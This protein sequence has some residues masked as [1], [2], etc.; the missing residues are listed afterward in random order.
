MIRPGCMYYKYKGDEL[1]KYRIVSINKEDSTV[2]VKDNDGKRSTIPSSDLKNYVELLPDAMLHLMI[3]EKG[4]YKDV[5]VCIHRYDAIAAGK[6]EPAVIV[7]QDAINDLGNFTKPGDKIVVG[8]CVTQQTLIGNAGIMDHVDFD[9]VLFD[10]ITYI[11]LDDTLDSI[12]S[13]IS[14]S[15]QDKTNA[16]LRELTQRNNDMI[17]GYCS[18]LKE[19]LTHVNFMYHYRSIFNINQVDWMVTTIPGKKPDTFTLPTEQIGRIQDMLRKYITNVMAIAYD[20]DLDVSK[21]VSYKHILIS[22]KSGKIYLVA[23][24]EVGNYAVDNDIAKAMGVYF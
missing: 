7:R 18:S 13:V 6:N 22:D 23:Y 11:Y 2:V 14:R 20:H 21:I 5:Y 17:T 9:K 8:E 12:M 19:L 10:T 4:G 24:S 3:T 16:V 15:A 1:V